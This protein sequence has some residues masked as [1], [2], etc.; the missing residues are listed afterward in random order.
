MPKPRVMP[1]IFW[2]I[3]TGTDAGK[4]TI[5]C[6][7]IR[8]LNRIGISAVGFKPYAKTLFRDGVDFLAATCP[9]HNRV[10]FGSDAYA[11]ATASPL[12]PVEMGEV[13]APCHQFSYPAWGNVFLTRLGSGYLGDVEFLRTPL[14]QDLMLRPDFRRLAER[15][16]LPIADARMMESRIGFYSEETDAV[17]AAAFSA[18]VELGSDAIV[19]EGAKDYLPIFRGAPVADHLVIV[20]ET[21]IEFYRS[22]NVAPDALLFGETAPWGRLSQLLQAVGECVST[23]YRVLCSDEREQGLE[24][25]LVSLLT[26]SGLVRQTR[27]T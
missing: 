17:K 21:R 7:L 4:T 22:I 9:P 25:M 11:L 27:P 24:E 23:P 12:T 3:G 1:E 18:L 14:A 13:I 2:V 19:C 16:Y 10:L 5:A 15:I 8:F 20:Y 6:A 26:R